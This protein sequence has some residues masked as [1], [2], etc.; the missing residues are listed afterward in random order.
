MGFKCTEKTIEKRRKSKFIIRSVVVLLI[1]LC[2]AGLLFKNELEIISS[3][4][5]LG[6]EKPAYYMEINGDYY[7]EDFLKAGGASSDSEV[8]A[9]LTNKI[10]KGFYS[11]DVENTGLACSTISAKNPNGAHMWGRNFD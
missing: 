5:D 4:K 7:F 9:F 1:V 2:G 6:V 11:V 8:S 10:S 3:I